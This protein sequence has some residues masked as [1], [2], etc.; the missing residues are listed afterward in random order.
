MLEHVLSLCVVQRKH[1]ILLGSPI[2]TL[3]GIQDTICSKKTLEVLGDRLRCLHAHD[4]LCLLRHAFVIPKLLYVI[5]T[6][7]CFLSPELQNFDSL[8]RSL[9][10]AILNIRLY[11][12]AWTQASLPIWCGGLGVRS[13]TQLAP[14]AYLASAVGSVNLVR[15]IVPPR[16]QDAPCP[17]V[18]TAL[19]SWRQGHTEPPPVAPTSCHQKAWDSPRVTAAAV[20]LLEAAQ[21]EATRA[22]FLA[23]VCS[24]PPSISALGLRM[25]DNVVRVAVGLCLGVTL[26]QPHQCHQCGT[27]VDQLGLHGFSCRMSQGRHSRHAAVNELIRRALASAKV[28]PHLEPSGTSHFICE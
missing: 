22:R 27:E 4:A 28:P 15:Q 13:A 3:E 2:G 23:T 1:A 16:L 7:P 21:D 26:C 18:S 14:S 8:V 11:V 24:P 19:N 5:H 20:A 9:L 10:C 25:D 17:E 6:S 12:S